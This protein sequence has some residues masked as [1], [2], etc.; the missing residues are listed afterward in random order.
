MIIGTI[1]VLIY[2]NN[3]GYKDRESF[4]SLNYVTC[5]TQDGIKITGILKESLYKLYEKEIMMNHILKNNW[6]YATAEIKNFNAQYSDY[7]ATNLILSIKDLEL[8]PISSKHINLFSI[9]GLAIKCAEE[10]SDNIINTVACNKVIT[11][12]NKKDIKRSYAK[13]KSKNILRKK[14][15][16]F[17]SVE[18]AQDKETHKL[19]LNELHIRAEDKFKRIILED[20]LI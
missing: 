12:N 2:S 6:F 17:G 7:T 1:K 16:I 15:D 8:C 13:L 18:L 3:Q 19:F 11:A 5:E 9:R 20:A 4:D 14:D 10:E